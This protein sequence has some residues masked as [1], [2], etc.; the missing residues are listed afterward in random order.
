MCLTSV[1]IPFL[2][3]LCTA[4]HLTHHTHMLP[5]LHPISSNRASRHM[6][7]GDDTPCTSQTSYISGAGQLL[8]HHI[9][10]MSEGNERTAGLCPAHRHPQPRPAC[11]QHCS[12]TVSKCAGRETSHNRDSWTA[13]GQCGEQCGTCLAHRLSESRCA[14]SICCASS[15]ISQQPCLSMPHIPDVAATAQSAPQATGSGTRV[16]HHH[17]LNQLKQLNHCPQTTI[18]C[19]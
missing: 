1:S 10:A 15:N 11:I 17:Q 6:Q 9:T 16:G 18:Q 5:N 14:L 13:F 12:A 4:S 3:G 8:A 2:L 19:A 7:M